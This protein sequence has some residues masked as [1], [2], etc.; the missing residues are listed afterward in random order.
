[1][2]VLRS[3]RVPGLLVGVVDLVVLSIPL[4]RGL[5]VYLQLKI[6]NPVATGWIISVS[7]LY[8]LHVICIIM[9]FF[10]SLFNKPLWVIPKLILKTFTI[11]L[12]SGFTFVLFYW[13]VSESEYLED[14]VTSVIHTDRYAS[15]AKIRII[16]IGMLIASMVFTFLQF[17]LMHVL[18]ESYSYVKEV[19]IREKVDELVAKREERQNQRPQCESSLNDYVQTVTLI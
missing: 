11:L 16:G 17:W 8:V 7:L 6:A 13:I 19:R 9:V 15:D 1:M 5:Y 10:G 12:C 14:L 18:I 2:N 3:S 4:V